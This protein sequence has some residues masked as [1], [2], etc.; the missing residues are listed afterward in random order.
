MGKNMWYV[1]RGAEVLEAFDN[2]ASAERFASMLGPDAVVV[3]DE[4]NDMVDEFDSLSGVWSDELDDAL[5]AEI[6]DPDWLD[7]MLEWIE[8]EG[9]G[10]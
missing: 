3:P 10:E 5:E 9:E 4:G 1:E 2:E 7:H 8:A 6:N